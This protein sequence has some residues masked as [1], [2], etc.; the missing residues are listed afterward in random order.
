M[1]IVVEI[2][3][4]LWAMPSLIKPGGANQSAGVLYGLC[5]SFCLQI[6]ALSFCPNSYSPSL[7]LVTESYHGEPIFSLSINILI[8]SLIIS[9]VY[10]I[11]FFYHTHL[12]LGFLFM[13]QS[14][15]SLQ[16]HSGHLPLTSWPLPAPR[17]N[18]VFPNI[19]TFYLDYFLPATLSPI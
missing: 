1:T 10:M 6:P 12:S 18:D 4:P 19:F 8:Y 11:Y 15:P 13:I 9:Y 17:P 14:L 3:S 2:P 7:P 16:L 5:F